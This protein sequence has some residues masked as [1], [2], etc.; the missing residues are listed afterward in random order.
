MLSLRLNE[1]ALF[2]ISPVSVT[3]GRENWIN[4]MLMKFLLEYDTCHLDFTGQSESHGIA[5]VQQ[6]GDVQPF[7]SEGLF[8]G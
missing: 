2:K 5:G 6:V 7:L 8:T 3:E 1:E 4:S